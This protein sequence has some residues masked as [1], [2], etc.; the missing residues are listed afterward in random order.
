QFLFA[1][2][3]SAAGVWAKAINTPANA[4]VTLVL[5]DKGKKA[6]AS[7]VSDGLNRG[8]QVLAVDLV[9]TGDAAPSQEDFEEFPLMLATTGQREVSCGRAGEIRSRSR[10]VLPRPVQRV[11]HRSFGSARRAG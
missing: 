9:F 10:S 11:R 6:A 3:L 8:A 1:N 2:G 7:M 5:N 4:P